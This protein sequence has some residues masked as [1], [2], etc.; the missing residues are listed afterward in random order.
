MKKLFLAITVISLFVS[1]NSSSDKGNGK[2][3]KDNK[4]ENKVV[5]EL[6]MTSWDFYTNFQK[7]TENYVGSLK[8]KKITISDILI[9]SG[10]FGYMSGFPSDGNRAMTYSQPD[11]TTKIIVNNIVMQEYLGNIYRIEL[12]ESVGN[13]KMKIMPFEI[14][15]ED[16]VQTFTYHTVLTVQATGDMIEMVDEYSIKITGGTIME[17]YNW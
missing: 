12:V 17:H 4:V 10:D 9:T 13:E 7:D 2:D 5:E 1:C 11:G 6:K 3:Q 15:S 8:D 14:K 16:N